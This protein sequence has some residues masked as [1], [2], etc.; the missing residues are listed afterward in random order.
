MPTIE[1]DIVLVW[2]GM[3]E[4]RDNESQ[5]REYVE[6]KKGGKRVTEREKEN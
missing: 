2:N 1:Y 5:Q 3:K 6:R 4:M